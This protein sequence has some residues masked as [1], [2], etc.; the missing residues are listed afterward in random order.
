MAKNQQRRVRRSETEW[1]TIMQRF[2]SSDLGSRAFCEREGLSPSSFHRWR[3]R[4]E[5]RVEGQFVELVPAGGVSAAP[6]GTTIELLLPNGLAI[7]V[8]S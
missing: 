4:V 7:R 1:A 8:R 5:A 3:H 2:E 6:S